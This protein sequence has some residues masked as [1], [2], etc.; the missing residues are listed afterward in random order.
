[1]NTYIILDLENPNTRG[2]SICAIAIT[3]V[4]D[5]KIVEEKYTLIDPEDRFDAINSQITGI[6]P[7]QVLYAPTLK[8][9]WTEIKELLENNVNIGHNITYELSVL[10][11]SLSRYDIPVPEFRYCC[12]LALS[13]KYI[14]SDS[15]HLENLCNDLGFT[16]KSH[17]ASEDV[18]A[19]H[20]LF[21]YI[22]TTYKVTK[23]IFANTRS[24]RNCWSMWMKD[25]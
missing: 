7:N 13:R 16:Y 14:Q 2:N 24:R 21:E 12:T 22:K 8:E 17:I 4:K 11:K 10:S 1:M 15:Y 20:Y 5:N 18:K 9:Y 23:T 19:A 3:V 25:S 6:Y